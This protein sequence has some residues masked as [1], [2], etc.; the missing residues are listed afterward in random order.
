MSMVDEKG[1]GSWVLLGLVLVGVEVL[2]LLEEFGRRR[3]RTRRMTN[4]AFGEEV[5]DKSF[6][7]KDDILSDFAQVH[8]NMLFGRGAAQQ[9][10]IFTV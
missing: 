5:V 10:S 4:L 7:D 6:R 9:L 8:G 1:G 3:R 2:T